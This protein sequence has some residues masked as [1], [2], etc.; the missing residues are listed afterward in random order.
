MDLERCPKCGVAWSGGDKCR[1]CGFVPV[2]AGIDF[3]KKKKRRMRR[4]VEPGSW[5]G[6]LGYASVGGLLY[7]GVAYKP[8]TDDWEFFRALLGQGRHHSVVGEWEIV[9]AITL[10]K[11][12]KTVMAGNVN[13][14]LFKFTN[15]GLVDID[16]HHGEQQTA[17]KG[18]YEVKGQMVSML[19]IATSESGA[20]TL[21]PKF[22]LQLAWTGPDT[23]VASCNGSEAL[24]MRRH[25]GKNGLAN[26]IH[27][28]LKG[29]DM[30]EAPDSVKNLAN[31]MSKGTREAEK[32][33]E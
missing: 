33:T 6:F 22:N 12:A 24:Y 32:D 31:T 28:G 21:P 23:V 16:L 25:D 7:F 15:N 2:G 3:K 29:G 27:L 26:L 11:S 17:A 13:K 10:D 1:Q 19:G 30:N 14:G 5:G 8:W 4:Y 9:K 20:G 18:R